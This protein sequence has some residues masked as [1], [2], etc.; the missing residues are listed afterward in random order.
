MKGTTLVT[1]PVSE[2]Y[3]TGTTWPQLPEMHGCDP[4][5]LS[6]FPKLSLTRSTACSKAFRLPGAE[7][8]SATS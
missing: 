7:K 2:A 8:M 3:F 4:L 1:Q 5:A 6:Y